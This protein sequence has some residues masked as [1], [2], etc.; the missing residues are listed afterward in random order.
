MVSECSVE[1]M[2][3]GSKF[4]L[5][6]HNISLGAGDTEFAARRDEE[7]SHNVSLIP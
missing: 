4:G 3:V 7:L 6:D 2:H 1:A 5:K